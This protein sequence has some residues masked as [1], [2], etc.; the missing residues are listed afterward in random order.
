MVQ[1]ALKVSAVENDSIGYQ[2]VVSLALVDQ[3]GLLRTV[4]PKEAL[5]TLADILCVDSDGVL[6][7]RLA[8]PGQHQLRVDLSHPD[9]LTDIDQARFVG[10]K[11]DIVVADRDCI[12]ARVNLCE[13]VERALNLP[14]AVVKDVVGDVNPEVDGL[15]VLEFARDVGRIHEVTPNQP[16]N[17]LLPLLREDMVRQIDYGGPGVVVDALEAPELLDVVGELHVD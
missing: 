4:H 3:P 11:L 1:P 8:A 17:Q 7:A 5:V 15:S 9:W 12:E 14:L 13:H 10:H 2:G 16:D 6:R